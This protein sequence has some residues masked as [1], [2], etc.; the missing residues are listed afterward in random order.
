VTRVLLDTQLVLWALGGHKRLPR[1]ARRLIERSEV[2]VSAASI[3]EMAIKSSLGKLDADPVA[4]NEALAPSGFE[5]LAVSG[6]HAAHVARLPPHHRDP[7]DRLLVAQ[8]MIEALVLVTADQQLAPY[9][10]LVRIV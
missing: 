3:W 4:V 2:F 1:E 10:G 7:F 5:E 9:G 6:D 8:S